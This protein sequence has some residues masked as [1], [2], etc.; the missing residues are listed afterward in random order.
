MKFEPA[1][2]GEVQFSADYTPSV[3]AVE[4]KPIT[5]SYAQA[6]VDNVDGCMSSKQQ[7]K[8]TMNIPTILITLIKNLP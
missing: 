3:P 8:W 2:S 4:D 7:K 6:H 1:K 5:D